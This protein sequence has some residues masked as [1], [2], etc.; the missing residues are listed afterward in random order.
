MIHKVNLKFNEFLDE[1]NYSIPRLANGYKGESPPVF[2]VPQLKDPG[3][4]EKLKVTRSMGDLP[5]P[6][7][8]ASDP[9][10]GNSN[11]HLAHANSDPPRSNGIAGVWAATESTDDNDVLAPLPGDT[12]GHNGSG[13]GP[14]RRGSETN[15]TD[16]VM[17]D[18]TTSSAQPQGKPARRSSL[19]SMVGLGG[20][21]S[22]FLVSFVLF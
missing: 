14:Q 11:G 16:S 8:R 5:V 21:A 12:N 18:I 4:R 19:A 22:K 7:R 3:E 1:G 17:S 10:S 15:D 9:V 2:K 20:S 13:H 6:A